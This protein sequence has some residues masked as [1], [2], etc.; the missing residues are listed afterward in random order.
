MPDE[1]KTAMTVADLAE[2]AEWPERNVLGLV[3]KGQLKIDA[4][5]A[6]WFISWREHDKAQKGKHTPW[7]AHFDEMTK[8]GTKTRL[9]WEQRRRRDVARMGTATSAR[10]C[11]NGNSDVGATFAGPE[12]CVQ[13]F[14]G[15]SRALPFRHAPAQRM[16]LLVPSKSALRTLTTT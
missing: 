14:S 1:D 2:R 13:D 11:S 10:R 9:E 3:E 16:V 4:K 6:A 5:D 12:R 7:N 15:P 8:L